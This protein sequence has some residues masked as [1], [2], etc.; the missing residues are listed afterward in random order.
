[1]MRVHPQQ[2]HSYLAGI[3]TD[4]PLQGTGIGSA[5]MR[6]AAHPLRRRRHACLPG[7][8]QGQQ[9]PFYER[10]GFTVTRELTIPGGGPTLWL[11]WRDPQPLG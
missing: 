10:H 8:Q 9:R 3:G 6:S 7:V 2:P 5:L 11:M 4:P 1:M